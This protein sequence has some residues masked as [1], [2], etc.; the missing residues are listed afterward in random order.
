MTGPYTRT[1]PDAALRN[2]DGH[3]A[4]EAVERACLDFLRG[5][6]PLLLANAARSDATPEQVQF[7]RESADEIKK[8]HNRILRKSGLDGEPL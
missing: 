1:S 7:L 2:P 8:L 4:R 3:T 5:G 6:R